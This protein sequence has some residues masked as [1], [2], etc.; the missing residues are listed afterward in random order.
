ML[1]P[2]VLPPPMK[3]ERLMTK[4]EKGLCQYIDAVGTITVMASITF[5]YVVCEIL[6]LYIDEK[7]TKHN[8][9]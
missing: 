9:H 2:V 3:Q 1:A 6:I 8:L 7:N 4:L 5:L